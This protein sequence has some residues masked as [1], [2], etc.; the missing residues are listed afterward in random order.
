MEYYD[1][2]EYDLAGRIAKLKTKNGTMETPYLFP[3]VDPTRQD[4][5]LYVIEKMGFNAFITNAYLFYRRNRGRPKN[6]HDTLKWNKVIMTDSGGYQVLVYGDI[7]ID[8]KTIIEYEKQIGVDIGV[9]LDVPTGTKMSWE[10]ARR[11]VFETFDR[12]TEALPLIMDTDQL[13][14]LPIQGAPYRDL[15]LYSSLRAWKYPYHIHAL[16]SPTVLLERYDYADIVELVAL[17]RLHLP[18]QKPLHVFGVGHPMIL[19]FLVALGADLF[20]SASYILYARDG[21]YMTETGTRRLDELTYLPCNCPVCSR[22]TLAELKS[23]KRKEQIKLLATHNLYVLMEEL[24][25]IKEHI[26]EGRLWEY[27]EYKS[28]AHPS[29]RSAFNIVK[30]YVR[31]LEKYNPLTK[32]NTF[33][34]MMNDYD[35]L[36]HPRLR[37]IKKNVYDFVLSKLNLGNTIYLVPA[38]R[39]PY[40]N[41]IELVKEIIPGEKCLFYHPFL[42]VFPPSLSNTYP[43][44]QHEYNDNIDRYTIIESSNEIADTII[45]LEEVGKSIVEVIMYYVGDSWSESLSETVCDM[46]LGHGIKCARHTLDVLVRSQPRPQEP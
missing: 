33:A 7:E 5:P 14:V 17:A 26:K 38:I 9:I 29:L 37:V 24:R 46:L 11:A 25:K 13:W 36:Y 10:E 18:P 20:D 43:F 8:N 3:V 19:P 35:S 34:I 1:P 28:K 4:V 6:I 23:L 21:R 12:A 2:K 15:V 39:K 27:L 45:R 30:K 42:G 41:I 32:P 31:L 44:F 40:S 16:G 22:Y